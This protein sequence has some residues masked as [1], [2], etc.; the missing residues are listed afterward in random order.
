MKVMK[1][2]PFYKEFS[3]IFNHLNLRYGSIRAPL[4]NNPL[5]LTQIL[6]N[7]LKLSHKKIHLIKKPVLLITIKNTST[8]SLN[9]SMERIKTVRNSF[10]VLKIWNNQES[11]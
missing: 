9:F 2:G 1:I 8:Y 3:R 4:A 6:N 11:V 10:K 7:A 5:I